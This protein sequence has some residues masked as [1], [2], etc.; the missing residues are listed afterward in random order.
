MN[1]IP[2]HDKI[3][4][5]SKLSHCGKVRDILSQCDEQT[6]VTNGIVQVIFFY[7]FHKSFGM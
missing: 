4:S 7:F 5:V 6:I 1:L 2:T 3:K